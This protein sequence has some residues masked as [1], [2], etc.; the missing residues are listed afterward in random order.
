MDIEAAA[1]AMFGAYHA[2]YGRFR[3]WKRAPMQDVGPE[4]GKQIFLIMAQAVASMPAP[5]VEEVAN[6]E[7]Y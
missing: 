5:E 7:S 2:H 6:G 1:E 4:M 3:D